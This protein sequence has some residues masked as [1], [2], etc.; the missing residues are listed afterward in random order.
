DIVEQVFDEGLLPEKYGVGFDPIGVSAMVDELS[1]RGIE[2][3]ENG[4]P[5]GAVAQGYRL[6]GAI[7]GMERKLSDGTFI[8]AGQELMNFCVGNAKAERRGNAIIIDKQISGTAKIDPLIGSFNAFKY[9]ERN[10]EAAG[11]SVYRE[12]GLLM[13][14]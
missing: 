13:V 6:A 5:V 7:W 8:H 12:R 14:G 3:A 2:N 9:M 1:E 10:P 11:K 4:G